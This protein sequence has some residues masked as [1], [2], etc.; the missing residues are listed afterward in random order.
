MASPEAIAQVQSE[1]KEH[2]QAEDAQVRSE[3]KE[4]HSDASKSGPA[5]KQPAGSS[6]V[7]SPEEEP[8]FFLGF[9]SRYRTT[10]P[11]AF[12]VDCDEARIRATYSMR[13]AKPYITSVRFLRPR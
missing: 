10:G 1:W 6:T 12:A 3:L 11:G 4:Q 2:F 5:E 8:S 7:E 13:G 9:L